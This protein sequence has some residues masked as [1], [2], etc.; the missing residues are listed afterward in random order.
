M[1]KAPNSRLYLRHIKSLREIAARSTACKR[2]ENRGVCT[3]GINSQRMKIIIR[4]LI[5][6][7]SLLSMGVWAQWVWVD[8]DGRKVFSDRAPD[9]G[10]PEKNILKRPG[11]ART[12]APLAN[13]AADDAPGSAAPAA[14]GGAA[15]A[16]TGASAP[17]LSAA[18]K[19][20]AERK[21][22]A[23]QAE[24]A[25][26]KAEDDKISKTRADNCE[27]AKLAKTGL[28][29]G[30][31]VSR[32]NKQGEREVMDDAARAA[33]TKRIQSVIDSDCN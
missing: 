27:R 2:K 1:V 7:S 22:K 14:T 30:I 3:A 32:F 10:V 29:S 6:A 23:E 4:L 13:A 8:K 28:D 9:A 11:Q 26:R 5:V 24:L 17:K 18:D 33:E 20:L 12:T 31:R 15:T 25:K 19:E 21:K 16:L